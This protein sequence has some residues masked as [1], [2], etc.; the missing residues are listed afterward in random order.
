MLAPDDR[1]VL[2]DLLRPPP[3]TALD[4]A[5]AT[6]F[7]LDLGAALVA[8]LAFAAFDAGGPG[9]PIAAL[10]AIR[11]VSDRLTVFCQAGEMRVPAAASDLFGF[12]EHVVHEVRRPRA[13]ALFHPKMWLP[14]LC[15]RGGWADSTRCPDTESDRRRQLGR[16]PSAGRHSRRGPVV[17]QPPTRRS[18]QVVH[19]THHDPGR[20]CASRERLAVSG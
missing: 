7:T 8:P 2:L 3:D 17:S 14:S 9:D 10:E 5:V 1:S 4:V 18:R 6:T 16:C 15:R 12:L 19:G 11:S 13:G 20:R